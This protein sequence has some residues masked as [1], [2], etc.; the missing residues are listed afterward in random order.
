MS[1]ARGIMQADRE[2]RL[3]TQDAEAGQDGRRSPSADAPPNL[4]L[5]IQMVLIA[6]RWRSLLDEQLRPLGQSSARM[7]TMSAIAHAPASSQ[8]IEL[9][10]R[11]GVEAATVTRMLDSL[12]AEGLVERLADPSDRRAKHIKLTKTGEAALAEVTAVAER[13]RNHLLEGIAPSSIDKANAFLARLLSRLEED[14]PSEGEA[15]KELVID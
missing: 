12:E 4:R 3:Q 13:L 11:L 10:K 6:R 1:G 15:G 8:Q 14:L 2:K 9:A 7:E 5:T